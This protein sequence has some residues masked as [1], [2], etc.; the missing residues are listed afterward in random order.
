M[1]KIFNVNG[2]CRPAKHYMV[3]LQS[4]L[5]AIKSMVDAGDY[6][7]MNR[8]RQYGKTTTLR[9]L[10]AFLE[11]YYVVISLDFQKMSFSDFADESAF[12]SGLATKAA[13]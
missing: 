13:I 6:F 5:E 11:K 9:A 10:A 1:A 4:R 3:N 2:A 7:T 12:V 8:A